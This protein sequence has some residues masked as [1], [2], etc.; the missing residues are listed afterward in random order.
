MTSKSILLCK[1]DSPMFTGGDAAYLLNDWMSNSS[2]KDLPLLM[3]YWFRKNVNVG[4]EEPDYVDAATTSFAYFSV[5]PSATA[6]NDVACI[7]NVDEAMQ[8]VN[9]LSQYSSYVP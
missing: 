6:I 2:T 8:W 4:I 9:S 1:V 5:D 7:H 3:M